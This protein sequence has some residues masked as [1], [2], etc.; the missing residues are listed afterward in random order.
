MRWL[1]LFLFPLL[2]C[3]VCFGQATLL[4][5]GENG[6]TGGLSISR[7]KNATAG[8]LHLGAIIGGKVDLGV[9]IGRVSGRGVTGSV[10]A[11]NF[12]GYP[13]RAGTGKKN[14]SI[15]VG[16]GVEA[17]KS[18]SSGYYYSRS[19]TETYPK[20]GVGLSANLR[21]DRSLLVQPIIGYTRIIN[22]KIQNR[23]F[24]EIGLTLAFG[25]S[26]KDLF[27]ISSGI[28]LSG[29]VPTVFVGVRIIFRKNSEKSIPDDYTGGKIKWED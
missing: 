29:D 18:E 6:F 19:T 14:A 9:G 10:Y 7:N 23:D 25:A 2:I 3:S 15:G 4:K 13:I 24:G 28:L 5:P 22:E 17:V 21:A 27:A 1:T 11:F 16:V 20:V 26:N 12:T 8:G